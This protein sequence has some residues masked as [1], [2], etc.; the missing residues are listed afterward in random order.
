MKQSALVGN[1]VRELLQFLLAAN[2]E[3]V[4]DVYNL[5]AMRVELRCLDLLD[6]ILE[7]LAGR[8]DVPHLGIERGILVV[9]VWLV[10]DILGLAHL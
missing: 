7:F 4:L 6:H 8:L 2:T 3:Y 10:Q 1:R 5:S 9:H